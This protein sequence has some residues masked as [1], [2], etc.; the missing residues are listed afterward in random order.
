MNLKQI[1]LGIGLMGIGCSGA[2][3]CYNYM[4]NKTKEENTTR[5]ITTLTLG[6]IGGIAGG[7]TF[8]KGLMAENQRQNPPQQA[9]SQNANLPQR[10][11]PQ[12]ERILR[13]RE[14]C[15]RDQYGR[16]IYRRIKEER[17]EER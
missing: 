14:E 16:V 1:V 12:R 6:L 11:H 10:Q 5:I 7:I 9:Y 15:L 17:E 2:Y 3:I 8:K 13:E 4:P